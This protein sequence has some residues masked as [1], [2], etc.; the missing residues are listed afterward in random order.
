MFYYENLDKLVLKREI[1]HNGITIEAD[2]IIIVSGYISAYP[3]SELTTLGFKKITIIGGM[4]NQGI[5][6]NEYD[7]L[8]NENNNNDNL[9]I[10]ITDKQIHS[11]IYIW[12]KNGEVILVLIGSANFTKSGLKINH[13]ECLLELGK[14]YYPNLSSYLDYIEKTRIKIE[15]IDKRIIVCKPS[16]TEEKLVNNVSKRVDEFE[17][18]NIEVGQ[19]IS[20]ELPLFSEKTGEVQSGHG[21]NWG[22]SPGN[23]RINDSCIPIPMPYIRNNIEFFKSYT[24]TDEINNRHILLIWD[25]GFK[26]PASF[27]GNQNTKIEESTFPK[28]IA[29]RLDQSFDLGMDYSGITAKSIMGVY[30]RR[31]MKLELGSF[32][33]YQMLKDYGRTTIKLTHI[34]GNTYLADFSV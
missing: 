6:K 3:I 1:D 17:K 32:I 34:E 15:D 20:I 27:E 31:R 9:S 28:Q 22:F 8:I 24:I 5:Y 26:M 16:F 12:K 29:S 14:E 30:I 25:D 4:Y 33:N 19:N 11:K 2:E 7:D 10:Y 23:I 21:L 18:N 13:R